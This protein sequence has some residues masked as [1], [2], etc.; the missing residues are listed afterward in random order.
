MTEDRIVIKS[1]GKT[2]PWYLELDTAPG[3][4]LPFVTIGPSEIT[5]TM[6]GLD[7]GVTIVKGMAT[8]IRDEAPG[9]VLK[10]TPEEGTLEIAI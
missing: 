8:D 10:L 2:G 5:A 7:Y 6:S 3:A 1:K 9:K 4:S